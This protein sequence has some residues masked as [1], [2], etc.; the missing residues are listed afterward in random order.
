MYMPVNL[1]DAYAVLG[2]NDRAFMARPSD[3]A[4]RRDCCG[5]SRDLHGNRSDVGVPPRRSEIQRPASPHWPAAVRLRSFDQALKV[6]LSR[7][8]MRAVNHGD[9][10]AI[11]IRNINLIG[12]GVRCD[13]NGTHCFGVGQRGC[14]VRRAVNDAYAAW[15]VG[16]WV[17][18]IGNVYKVRLR[19]H[20]YSDGECSDLNL[21]ESIRPSITVTLLL[22]ELVT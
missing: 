17:A 3:C 15:V 7:S 1:A 14:G 16:V 4:P 18:V 20:R 21:T 22:P 8:F 6:G 9:V 12:D 10:V 2:E 19:V 5:D 11:P 13:C